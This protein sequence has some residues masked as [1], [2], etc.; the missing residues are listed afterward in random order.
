MHRERAASARAHR[1]RERGRRRAE[2]AGGG[3]DG[4]QR[5]HRARHGPRPRGCRG[6]GGGLGPQRREEPARGGRAGRARRPSGGHRG[7]RGRRGGGQ[8][9]DPRDGRSLR[10]PRR[11]R[12]QRGHEHPQA[13]PGPHARGVAPGARHQP[14]QRV[15]R[16]PGRLPDHEARRRRQDHQHRLDD[17]ALRHLVRPG[18]RGVEGRDRA[19]HPG[20]GERVGAR[21]HP[22]QRGAARVDRHRADPERS[23]RST[24]SPRPRA[25]AHARGPLGRGRRSLRNR[26]FPRRAASDFVTGTAIPVDGGYSIQG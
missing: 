12:Q 15:P 14:H 24:R 7:R 25:R 22:G 9:L 18:L 6:V 23:E 10:A 5:R 8:R 11:A 26:G 17:V 3:G 13:G 20:D 19:A 16:E 2:G 4:R 21:Q 1:R